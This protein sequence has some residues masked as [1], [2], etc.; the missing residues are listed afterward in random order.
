MTSTFKQVFCAHFRCAP[1]DFNR[2]ALARC[3]Y[4]HAGFVWK[5]LDLTGGPAV[6]AA[7]SFIELAGQTKTKEDLLDVIS[8]YR[9]DIKPHSG[10]LAQHFKV[11]VSIDRLIMLHDLIRSSPAAQSTPPAEQ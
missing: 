5:I 2:K 4:P 10:F 8:E 6:L 11:R 1:E 3:L 7:Y 9:E